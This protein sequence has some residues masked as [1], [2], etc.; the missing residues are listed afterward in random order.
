M[1]EIW[2][3]NGVARKKGC[4]SLVKIFRSGFY[5]VICKI[6]RQ[7]VKVAN[8]MTVICIQLILIGME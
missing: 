8:P 3:Q 2:V 7:E 1:K 6:T 5:N 4:E